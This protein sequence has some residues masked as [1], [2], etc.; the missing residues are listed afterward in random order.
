MKKKVLYLTRHAIINY[1]S[2][3]QA[4]ATQ[5][6]IEKTG[7]EAVCIDYFRADEKPK[8][9]VNTRLK[10]SKW[11]K[12]VLTRIVYL[13]TQTPVYKFA[14]KRFERYRKIVKIT[15]KQYNSGEDLEKNTPKADVYLT[16]SDQVWNTVTCGEI[17]YVYFLN[18]L[19]NG[20]KK[21]A[22]GASFGGATVREK[23]RNKIEAL[24][25]EYD[26]VAIRENSGVEIAK[27]M[28]IDA[29]QVL[30]P[31]LLLNKEEWNE[32]IAEKITDEK[33]VLVYQIHPNKKFVRYAKEF[34]KSKGLRLI[35]ISPFFHH[36]VRTGKFVYCPDLGEFLRYINDAEYFLTDSFH[37]TAFAIG[38]NTEFV[39]A[40]P[41]EYSERLS[42]ILQLIGYENRILKDYDDF[43]IAD[44]K[45]DYEKVNRIIEIERKKSFEFL[46]NMIGD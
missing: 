34:A 41:S 19:K 38:L 46:K 12:N 40:L 32:I 4:Y 31:T 29:M 37:G 35:R 15:P 27:K 3:L 42:S 24:L 11:N 45:I 30:D 1:G 8:K 6:A 2:V 20:E 44:E 23:D 21:V 16:G 33:Y 13:V 43:S 14:G 26:K 28:G 36:I 7:N 17:D 5:R 10:N 18:F 9:L 39:D 22:Y 25:S